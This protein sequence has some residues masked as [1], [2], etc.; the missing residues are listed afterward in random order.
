L[1][2]LIYSKKVER[3]IEADNWTFNHH[4][5][6]KNLNFPFNLILFSKNNDLSLLKIKNSILWVIKINYE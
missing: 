4:Y 1:N 2:T 5:G 3:N 6:G